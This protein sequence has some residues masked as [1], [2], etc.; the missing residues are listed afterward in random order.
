MFGGTCNFTLDDSPEHAA[1][2]EFLEE[3]TD[4]TGYS[5]SPEEKEPFIEILGDCTPFFINRSVLIYPVAYNSLPDN[6]KQKLPTV[7]AKSC[8]LKQ[9]K[10]KKRVF[11]EHLILLTTNQNTTY[12]ESKTKLRK[13]CEEALKQFC[14]KNNKGGQVRDINR[15][16]HGISTYNE[17]NNN[18]GGQR[19]GG[20]KGGYGT[21]INNNQNNNNRG[22]GRDGN[23]GGRVNKNRGRQRP[24]T[25][26]EKKG[27]EY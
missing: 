11:W 12:E 13:N 9:N 17:Q 1:A 3:I 22:Q 24:N 23:R 19:R 2:R 27:G 8:D 14:I 10:E 25:T 5:P 15:G 16:G 4:G 6:V 26:E 20:S 18:K 7:E 21:S